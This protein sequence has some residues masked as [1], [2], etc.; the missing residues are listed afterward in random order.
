MFVNLLLFPIK[1]ESAF[2]IISLEGFTMGGWLGHDK[3]RVEAGVK[4]FLSGVDE[5]TKSQVAAAW[6]FSSP[7]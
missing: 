2:R 3:Q 7:I 6:Q 5:V 4:A 1:L